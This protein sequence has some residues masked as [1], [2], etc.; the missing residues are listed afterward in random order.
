MKYRIT[1]FLLL[2]VPG[3]AVGQQNR[4]L[5]LDEL[6]RLGSENSLRLNALR[7]QENI[8]GEQV[9]DANAGR[10]PD[11]RIGAT[12]GYLGQPVVFRQGLSRAT[13]P[14]S[15]DWL[16]NYNLSIVQ[17][18]W[19]GGR[20]RYSIER[21]AL[22]KQIA[23]LSTTDDEAAVKMIL[24]RQ[25]LDLFSLYKQKEV[26]AR[27]I[28]EA[29]RRLAD[30]RQMKKEGI[31]TLNDEIRSELELTDFRLGYRETED[32]IGLVSQQLDILLGLDETLLLEP[33]TALLSSPF[34]L[35]DY[36]SYVDQAYA[37]YPGMNI[38][39][40]STELARKDISI[41]KSG[42][43]PSLA[44]EGGNTLARPITTTMADMFSNS[45]NVL[46]SLSYNLSSLY[47]NRHKVQQA[48]QNVLLGQN[49]EQ[50]VMQQ[51]RMEVRSAYVRHNESLDRVESLRL[52]VRQADENYRIVNNRYMNQLSILTDLLDAISI[53]MQAEL[54]LT[55]A[56]AET[57]YT[58]YELL[59][60]CGTL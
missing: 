13:R 27:N 51:L 24:L 17:S 29:G 16:Q 48:R 47:Q 6:F 52:A 14:D 26:F 45:W 34:A 15:P 9:R 3:V 46:F 19:Q 18:I 41:A 21:A 11:I 55:T 49:R 56:R 58:Y 57:V 31:V 5:S 59:R 25:Y 4:F 40:Q 8:A 60:A 28:E 12:A 1:L 33:D 32:N 53:R 39:R 54:Q 42:Y 35:A 20:I 38:A 43:L 2:L 23:A 50:Q 7:I 44:V 36:E 10:L 30:I 37:A 22:Q